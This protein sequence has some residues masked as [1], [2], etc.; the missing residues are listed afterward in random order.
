MVE[1]I[2]KVEQETSDISEEPQPKDPFPNL[3]ALPIMQAMG[4]L[5]EKGLGKQGQG[6]TESITLEKMSIL[7]E[8]GEDPNAALA[9]KVA[10]LE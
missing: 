2:G 4:Y 5:E 9:G 10:L 1:V 6:I 3:M 8:L 7:L